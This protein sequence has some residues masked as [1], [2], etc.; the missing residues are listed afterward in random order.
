MQP[1][2]HDSPRALKTSWASGEHGRDSSMHLCAAGAHSLIFLLLRVRAVNA[3]SH[4]AGMQGSSD[5]GILLVASASL[6]GVKDPSDFGALV[7]ALFLFRVLLRDSGLIAATNGTTIL[8]A[9]L[10]S[11]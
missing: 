3:T 4:S 1:T 6:S 11:S 7:F 8:P 5:F 9:C 2:Q 10:L